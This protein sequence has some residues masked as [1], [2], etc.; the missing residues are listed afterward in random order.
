MRHIFLELAGASQCLTLC[1]GPLRPS[2][3]Q[4]P[5]ARRCRGVKGALAIWE[6]VSSAAA[7]A[8]LGAGP[9]LARLA[10]LLRVLQLQRQLPPALAQLCSQGCPRR[11]EASACFGCLRITNMARTEQFS[12]RAQSFWR[13]RTLSRDGVWHS[14]DM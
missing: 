14:K 9:A 4:E 8:L 11:L 13:H 6:H 7:G 12:C 1:V 5:L 2:A 3:A 10:L